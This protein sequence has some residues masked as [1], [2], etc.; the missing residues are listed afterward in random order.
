MEKR[1]S[2][3][4]YKRIKCPHCGNDNPRMIHDEPDKSEVLYYSMQGTPVY[5]MQKKCGNCGKIIP[6]E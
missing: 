3:E 4:E 5:K 1:M 6:K 2:E